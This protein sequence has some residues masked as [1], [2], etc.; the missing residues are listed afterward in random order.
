MY[1]NNGFHQSFH[2]KTRVEKVVNVR[3]HSNIE[4]NQ[5][6]LCLPLSSVG[7]G[8]LTLNMERGLNFLSVVHILFASHVY[9]ISSNFLLFLSF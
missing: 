6:T 3:Y 1:E 4:F 9:K 8:S 7:K 5:G 2:D